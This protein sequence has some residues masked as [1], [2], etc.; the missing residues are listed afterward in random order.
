MHVGHGPGEA[1]GA[2]TLAAAP[3]DGMDMPEAQQPVPSRPSPAVILLPDG[4]A[5]SDA[6]K[7]RRQLTLWVVAYP[8][9][10]QLAV[11]YD[12]PSGKPS[13]ICTY[14]CPPSSNAG[15]TGGRCAAGG[16]MGHRAVRS[17][18]GACFGSAGGPARRGRL[19]GVRVCGGAGPL[20]G[21]GQAPGEG[22]ARALQAQAAGALLKESLWVSIFFTQHAP[23]WTCTQLLKDN[24]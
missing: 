16:C 3:L 20:G 22:G 17:C 15:E 11:Q 23:R 10:A 6:V 12:G 13:Q 18:R 24:V 19:R 14:L 9:V 8:A 2:S 1:A 5:M 21:G 4:Q 7:V